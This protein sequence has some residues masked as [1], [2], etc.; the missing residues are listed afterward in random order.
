MP[1]DIKKDTGGISAET[2]KLTGSLKTS[3]FVDPKKEEDNKLHEKIVN[4]IAAEYELCWKFSEPK[5]KEWL[6][7]LKWYNNQS[8][9]KDKVG[10][11]LMFSV[12]STVLASLYD[13]QF[14]VRFIGREEGDDEKAENLNRYS[15][16]SH[17]AMGKDMHDYDWDF[18]ATF[19]GRGYSLIN[20]FDRQMKVPQP[21][22]IDPT[23]FVRDPRCVAINGDSF[24][25][26]GARFFGREIRKTKAEME[27]NGSYFNLDSIKKPSSKD[28]GSSGSITSLVDTARQERRTA[29]GFEQFLKLD[30]ALTENYEESLIQWFTHYGGKKYIFELA[31]DKTLIVRVIPIDDD[32]WPIA[33]R[34][35]FPISHDFDGVSVM[36]LTEDKQRHRAVLANLGLDIAKSELYPM[37]LFDQ[38]KIKNRNNLNFEFNKWIPTNGPPGDA[39]ELLAGKQISNTV[40]Y[41]YNLLGVAA[42]RATAISATQQGVMPKQERTLGELELVSRGSNSRYGLAARIFGWSEKRFWKQWYNV[43][44]KN[45]KDGIDEVSLRLSGPFGPKWVGF[46]REDVIMNNPLGPDIKIESRVVSEA[47]NVRKFQ[48]F[49]S[50]FAVALQHPATD[51]RYSLRHLGSM[52]MTKD[53]LE[54]VWPPT[55]DEMEAEKENEKLNDNEPAEVLMEQ[56]HIEHLAV[57]ARASATKATLNHI[58]IHKRAMMM[59]RRAPQ[60]FPGLLREQGVGI[61]GQA[62]NVMSPASEP[63]RESAAPSQNA[64]ALTAA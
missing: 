40:D 60:L 39:V 44:S 42:E 47:Q 32:E 49:Q 7:R 45:L 56:N 50:Y 52:L 12:H 55:I 3:L 43:V 46:G 62:I 51:K 10:D 24:G 9:N 33:E 1:E 41:I 15:E 5:I 26:N 16:Y 14:A 23:T 20:D 8:R 53:Q 57:H 64:R 58:E 34:T 36:D 27:E 22:I 4:Q 21:E 37:R 35:I 25:R 48:Q 54:R 31:K 18:D 38:N 61:K 59:A 6:S 17:D 2:V 63:V 29:S 19:F 13:D 30:N 11:N 28:S